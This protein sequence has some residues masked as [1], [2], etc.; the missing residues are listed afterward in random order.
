MTSFGLIFNRDQLLQASFAHE[1]AIGEDTDAIAD[2]LSLR[3]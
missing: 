3:Q 1:H 2:F